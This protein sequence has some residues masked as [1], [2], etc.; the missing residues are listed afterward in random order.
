M[1]FVNGIKMRGGKTYSQCKGFKDYIRRRDH[2]TCQLCGEPGYEVDHIVPF[3]L[4]GETRPETSRV[5]CVKCNRSARLPRKDA[6]PHKTLDD[7]YAY[8]EAEFTK[9]HP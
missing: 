4:S 5:L 9:E 3:A 7:W 1:G 2:Y 6:N 8:L